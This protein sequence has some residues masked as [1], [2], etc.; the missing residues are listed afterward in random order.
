MMKVKGR[1][2]ISEEDYQVARVDAQVLDDISIG[3]GIIGKLYAGANA[4]YVRRKGDGELWLPRSLSY[5]ATGR[6]LVKRFAVHQMIEYL[7]YR[8]AN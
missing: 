6:A 4:S 1:A 2:W 5:A 3:W 7:D 8:K